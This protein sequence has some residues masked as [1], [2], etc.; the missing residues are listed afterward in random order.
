MGEIVGIT[1]GVVTQV[2]SANPVLTLAVGMI[3]MAIILGVFLRLFRQ[4]LRSDSLDKAQDAYVRNLA[5][6]L[7]AVR[8]DLDEAR[9]RLSAVE[10]E[11]N[12]LYRLVSET[13]AQVT[14][15]R[16]R[17]GSVEAE[18]ARLR[19]QNDMQAEELKQCAVEAANNLSK[20]HTLEQQVH[21]LQ[22]RPTH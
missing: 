11:R 21:E 17:L 10:Q 20:I 22:D 9:E 7:E 5:T 4:T 3:V 19:L 2:A 14:I 12:G 18:N 13:S 1:P 15:L 8:H 16:D 6:Q